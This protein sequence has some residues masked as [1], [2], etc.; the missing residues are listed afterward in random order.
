MKQIILLVAVGIIFLASNVQADSCSVNY[1]NTKLGSCFKMEEAGSPYVDE[2]NV[3]NLTGALVPVQ[4]TGYINN[5]Q[6]FLAD[7]LTMGDNYESTNLTFSVMYKGNPAN[8]EQIFS[9]YGG[10]GSQQLLFQFNADNSISF[11]VHNG[12]G[13][14]SLNSNLT[15]PNNNWTMVSSSYTYAPGYSTTIYI[16]DTPAGTGA[17]VAMVNTAQALE[18]GSY[19]GGTG[20]FLVGD[21]D[22]VRIFNDNL[23][24]TC[25]EKLW[26]HTQAGQECVFSESINNISATL[27][28][29]TNAT[30]YI[31]GDYNGSLI[32]TL[33][34][35]KNYANCNVNNTAWS[36]VGDTN[37]SNGTMQFQNDAP[38][39]DDNIS[40]FF[41]CNDTLENWVNF[42][43][44]F[45]LNT[46]LNIT[47]ID[48]ET[49]TLLD[50]RNI[51]VN[52]V[53]SENGTNYTVT[54]GY[55]NINYLLFD[56]YTIV[57]ETDYH[58]IRYYPFVVNQSDNYSITLYLINQSIV[59]S[60]S[61]TLYDS[62]GNELE[63]YNIR[64]LKL[65]NGQYP[66]VEICTTDFEGSCN[67]WAETYT[68][69]YK[70]II[71]K[72]GV[73]YKSTTAN[74]IDGTGGQSFWINLDQDYT[75]SFRK[76]N[77]L[78]YVGY[79]NN[80]NN[81]FTLTYTDT[82]NSL[83]EI[84]LKIY[85][86][87]M[88]H[89]ESLYNQSCLTTASGT[90]NLGVIPTNGTSYYAKAYASFSPEVYFDSWVKE[91]LGAPSIG[92]I[93]LF[94]TYLIVGGIAIAGIWFPVFSLIGVP[95]AFFVTK[96]ANLHT[97]S[98]SMLVSITAVGFILAYLIWRRG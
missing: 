97:Y 66:L 9:K 29:P 16:N 53:W 92:R 68:P 42:T 41:T 76:V 69:F 36:I 5:G 12:A 57:Y 73:I 32:L 52:V 1:L 47:F 60:I 89:E 34:D 58:A 21:V 44:W 84:C 7:S 62:Y 33:A 95:I 20:E 11:R 24:R 43:A 81:T 67:I 46:V 94:Y 27:D 80:N 3:A 55:L 4:T 38:I 10:A 37:L 14:T 18:V 6:A 25:I 28:Y 86:K 72:D 82:S 79:F 31:S 8:T 54:T 51:S 56:T 48:E 50:F 30:E 70:F 93:G 35:V 15:I 63:G 13:L 77:D 71:E 19:N 64:A 49:N 22:V 39:I 26:V 87:F 45:Y 88:Y 74:E 96:L 83:N 65:I 75:S 59:D 23:N 90:I 91:F 61:Q 40:L 2:N 17:T 98:N 85:S 78:L